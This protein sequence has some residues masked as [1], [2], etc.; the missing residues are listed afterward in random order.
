MRSL[1][2]IRSKRA[3]RVSAFLCVLNSTLAAGAQPVLP[4]EGAAITAGESDDR[5]VDLAREHF[6][7]G[8]DY[9]RAGEHAQA[10]AEFERA[11]QLI[12]NYRVLYNIGQLYLQMGRYADARTTLTKY[13][14]EGG[15][16]LGEDRV[17]AVQADLQLLGK[18]TAMIRVQS[19]VAGAEVSVDDV[20]VGD[21]PL[22]DP[23][24]VNAGVHRVRIAK[25]GYG[26]RTERVTM[27]GAQDKTLVIDLQQV[28]STS[29]TIVV[30]ER[31]REPGASGLMIASWVTTGV[32]AAGAITTGVM[33]AS[34]ASELD[35]LRKSEG[36]LSLRED[37]RQTRNRARTLLVASDI[38]SGAALIAGGASVWLSVK[39]PRRAET[40]RVE[41][42]LQVGYQSG[43]L[44]VRGHF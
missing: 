38:F 23:L 34:E 27:L 29:R 18:R 39:K 36:D 33:G 31:T 44:R 20:I 43:Q 22:A 19:N 24:L 5:A 6:D 37:L 8:L 14:Q 17:R 9:H 32:L 35:R 15:Q 42:P 30:R 11:Y 7:R 40:E 12:P 26:S 16:N 1:F 28:E 4:A 25:A 2:C 21:T 10:L 41:Q 13:L 3:L